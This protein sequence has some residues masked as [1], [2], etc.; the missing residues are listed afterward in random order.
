MASAGKCTVYQHATALRP[1]T[2]NI[3]FSKVLVA[4]CGPTCKA[5]QGQLAEK[6]VPFT[7]LSE[8]RL[9]DYYLRKISGESV[10]S[11]LKNLP[12]SYSTKIMQPRHCVPAN[13]GSG[14]GSVSSSSGSGW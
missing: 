1:N 11:E 12:V 5:E 3:C 9:A 8:G 6:V 13:G 2:R 4:H 14:Y 10:V 7:C